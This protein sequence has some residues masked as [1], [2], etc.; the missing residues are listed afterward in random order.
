[1]PILLSVLLLETPPI[2]VYWFVYGIPLVSFYNIFSFFFLWLDNFKWS[3]FDC[4]DSSS[5][6]FQNFFLVL[7]ILPWLSWNFSC[8]IFLILLSCLSSCSSLSFLL[9]WLFGILFRQFIDIHFI[10]TSSC[11][12]FGPFGSVM[13]PLLILILVAFS[14]RF[15]IEELGT[16]SSLTGFWWGKPFIHQH[17]LGYLVQAPQVGATAGV[18]SR[19]ILVPGSVNGQA[20]SLYLQGDQPDLWSLGPGASWHWDRP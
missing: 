19:L 7:F 18:L 14:W 2:C 20:F 6:Q 10:R 13:F 16:S 5:P 3:V 8:I 9:R 12:L 4:S 17:K 11:A 1:M 15:L